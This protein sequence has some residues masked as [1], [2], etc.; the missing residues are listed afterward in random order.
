MTELAI[1][2]KRRE[3]VMLSASLQRATITRRISSF[4]SH[5]AQS[6]L[7]FAFGLVSK[8]AAVRLGFAVAAMAWRLLR[9]RRMR[10]MR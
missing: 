10:R 5:P 2:E 6:L 4:E 3:L 1:L 9:K 8:P 7:Q